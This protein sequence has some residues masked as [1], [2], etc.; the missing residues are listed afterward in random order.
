MR[1]K[2][3]LVPEV[4]QTSAMDCGAASLKCLLEGFGIRVSYG[5]LREACQT[6]VDGTSIDTMEE[7]AVQLGLEAEQIMVP[8]DHLLLEGAAALPA[9]V[10]IRLPNGVTH[11]VV[12]WQ[13]FGPL[14]ELM[15]PGTGR[16][17]PM[18][19][20][21]LSE[22][23]VHEAAVPASGWREWAGSG[24]FTRALDRRL[25]NLGLGASAAASLIDSALGDTGWRPIAALDAAT[26]TLDSIV[27]SGGLRR[28][29]SAEKVLERL[30]VK[31]QAQGPSGE[32]GIP[33]A[34]WSVRSAP[35]APGGSDGSLLFRGAVLVRAPRRRLAGSVTRA[36]KPGKPTGGRS[37]AGDADAKKEVR[38]AYE[39]PS[40]AEVPGSQ[41]VAA[42]LSPELVAA[43]EEPPARPGMELMRL[44]RAD[45]ALAP[46]MVLFALLLATGGVVL[47]A[48]L[49]RGLLDIARDL[50]LTS[51]RL[52]AL[53]V[54]LV[55]STALLLLE[56]PIAA[57]ALRMGRKLESR[58]RV[59]FLEKI[60]RL[61]DRYFHSRLTSDM[62][63]RSHSVHRIRLLPDLAG[64]LLRSVFELAL[65]TAGIIWLDR[66]L[67][68][69][70]VA[71]ALIGIALPLAAQ[72]MVAEQDLRFRSHTGALSRFY[73]DALLGLV[74]IRTHCAE[75]TVRREHESLL[76][77]WAH[78]GFSLQRIA[79]AVDAV[80]FLSGFGLAA[81]LL[82]DHLARSGQSGAVLLLV[83]WAL[84]LPVLGQ[85]AAPLAWQYPAHRSVTLRLLEPLGAPES[86]D[87][88]VAGSPDPNGIAIEVPPVSVSSASPGQDAR[89]RREPG[90][91][92]AGVAIAFEDV[93]VRVAGH[94]ILQEINLSVGPGEHVAIVGPSGAGKSSLVGILLGW[95]RPASG[96]V[97]VDGLALGGRLEQLRRE[98][99]WVDP[100][101]QIW[102]RSMLSNLEYGLTDGQPLALDRVIR[103]ADLRALL[104]KLPDGLQTPL[105]E[106][107]ALVSGGEGQRV[108][109]GRGLLRPR[110]RL[111]IL[112][113]P[114]SGLDRERRRAL[115]ARARSRWRDC[116]LLCI[117]HDVSETMGFERVLVIERG[118]VVED[119]TPTALAAQSS[120]RYCALLNA[121]GDVREGLWS[122]R[123]WRRFRLED[124]SLA[125]MSTAGLRQSDFR[126]SFYT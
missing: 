29:R 39:G 36:G 102:N 13:R 49:F 48:L 11:L 86:S 118:R 45:G 31:A 37:V 65:S 53:G 89:V 123:V 9:I 93:S 113:E 61:G 30:L 28:G 35:P 100:S 103:D 8:V 64:Q 7:V 73:M 51:Q 55:F 104:E 110:V 90:R 5:R 78:A 32:G 105:G 46:G 50:A 98:T 88:K 63:E 115:L 77:E 47:E 99:A 14:V 56:I 15:D 109:F 92:E 91:T 25:R 124:G 122:S 42:S 27:R 72:P 74:P 40:A 26:R 125:E 76:V 117:T 21:F 57:S 83:Y 10:V 34:Y 44:L 38:V 12:G 59:A 4:I 22:I 62:A 114:F 107:G 69:L 54:L 68:W 85:E 3:L 66:S 79:V 87:S 70:A 6:D 84:N 43:L 82:F 101:V 96:Q 24:E 1:V 95:H 41:R 120:S 60:P 67:A 121:E 20:R 112:D 97:L 108:R 80:Q 52:T 94:T 126:Q 16:R 75:R 106:A 71:A 81:W 58:L 116:T 18:C 111:A 119:S 19:E 23:Y 17:W 2:S 33:A